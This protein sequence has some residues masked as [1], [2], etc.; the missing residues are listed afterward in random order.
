MLHRKFI[1]LLSLLILVS[2]SCKQHVTGN[3]KIIS[4][5]RTV[6]AFTVVDLLGAAEVEIIHGNT[7]S[8]M[9]KGYDN[10]VPLVKTKVSGETLTVSTIKDINLSNSDLT[11]EITCPALREVTLSGAGNLVINSFHQSSMKVSLNGAGNAKFSESECDSVFATLS[12]AGNMHVNANDYLE[13]TLNGVGNIEYAGN[14]IVQSR[15]NGVGNV[16]KK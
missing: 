15:I 4:D 13:A 8:V 12:G 9:V 11:I 6:D 7:Y 5:E 1:L 10:I 2:F 16:S 3:G 14:P